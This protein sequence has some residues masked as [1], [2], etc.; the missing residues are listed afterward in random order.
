MRT[1]LSF[2]GFTARILYPAVL[3]LTIFG[4]QACRTYLKSL[5]SMPPGPVY[6]ADSRQQIPIGDPAAGWAFMIGGNYLGSGIPYDRFVKLLPEA[7]QDT[8]LAREGKGAKIPPGFNAF[9]AFNGAMVVAGNCLTCHGSTFE[10]EYLPGL[11]NSAADFSKS[12]AKGLGI[13]NLMIR[14]QYGSQSPEFLAWKQYYQFIKAISPRILTENAGASPAFRLEEACAAHR[15]PMDLTYVS[16][17]VFPMSGFN[18]GSDVPPLWNLKK[19]NALYYNG[20]GRG[21]FSKLLMQASVLGIPDSAYARSLMPGFKDLLAWVAAMEP[22]KFPRPIDPPLAATGKQIFIDKCQKCHGSYGPDS[23]YPNKIIPLK[24]VK[25]D[26]LYAKYFMG[27][28]GLPAWYNSSWYANTA[29]RSELKPSAGYIAPP[30]D[31]IWATAPFFHNGSVPTIEGVLNS[32][33]RPEV[34]VRPAKNAAYD[35]QKLGWVFSSEKSEKTDLLFDTRKP[36]YGNGGHTFGDK[37][38]ATERQAVIEYLKTL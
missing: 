36:G 12:Q 4:L 8:V 16:Q 33:E 2:Q 17:P 3:F 13:F 5:D 35:W 10:G 6:R 25:T 24:V 19:K 7:Y 26:S 23:E 28:S 30:L 18:I 22:P 34:W 1:L 20:M 21:D 11:G 31:G 29:P 15:N 9:T 27:Q 32:S 14:N 37:L 38:S